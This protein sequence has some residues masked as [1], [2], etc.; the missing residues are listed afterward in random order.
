MLDQFDEMVNA[1]MNANPIVTVTG[2]E[3]KFFSSRVDIS[4]GH[5]SARSHSCLTCVCGYSGVC[6]LKP[7][8]DQTTDIHRVDID[9]TQLSIRFFNGGMEK[10]GAWLFDFFDFDRKRSVNSPPGWKVFI[11][12]QTPENKALMFTGEVK[13]WE[14]THGIPKDQIKPGEERFM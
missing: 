3:S 4:R 8:H 13:S 10:Q 14:E 9:G 5:H 12:P 7:H 11:T 6:Q 1:R 2:G